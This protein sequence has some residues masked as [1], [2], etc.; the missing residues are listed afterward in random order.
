MKKSIKGI[1]SIAVIIAAV[2]FVFQYLGYHK[3]KSLYSEGMIYFEEEDYQ[4][5]NEFFEKALK[6]KTIFGKKF[7][8]EI[9]LFQAEGDYY[10]GEAKEAVKIYDELLNNDPKN[11]ALY[12]MKGRCYMDEEQIDEAKSIFNEGWENTKDV[13]FL[14]QLCSICIDQNDMDTA[15]SYINVGLKEGEGDEKKF[16]FNEIVIYEKMQEYKKAYEKAK[17]YCDAFPEDENGKKELT[18]LSTRIE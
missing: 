1:I 10:L 12:L 17:E 3:M 15:L 14:Q 6:K 18:F 8:Q 16:L 7:R 11:K 9:R 2:F 4:K 13:V 5:S